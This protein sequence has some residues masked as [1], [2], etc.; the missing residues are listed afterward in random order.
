VILTI[1]LYVLI[2]AIDVAFIVMLA[3]FKIMKLGRAPVAESST[4]DMLVWAPL[5]GSTIFGNIYVYKV[6][7]GTSTL[8]KGD[9]KIGT[10]FS[11]SLILNNAEVEVKKSGSVPITLMV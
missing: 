5:S 4:V 2:Y 3:L 1:I 6:I 10:V 11:F 8:V 9:E 7:K